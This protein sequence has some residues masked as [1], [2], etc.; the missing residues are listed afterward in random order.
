MAV[1][2]PSGN[3]ETR[4]S[5]VD[6][7]YPDASAGM[8][9]VITTNRSIHVRIMDDENYRLYRDDLDCRAFQGWVTT[10][11]YRFKIPRDA[12]WHVVVNPYTVNGLAEFT[13]RL[14]HDEVLSD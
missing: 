9:V 7:D 11:P 3:S 2:K 5:E 13:V 6:Y 1:D 14:M 10:S 4:V 12:H 8:S